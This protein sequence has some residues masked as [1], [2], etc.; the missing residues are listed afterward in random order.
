[1]ALMTLPAYAQSTDVFIEFQARCLTPM[2]EVR[3]S[4]ISGLNLLEDMA[5]RE[6]WVSAD[7]DWHLSR[8]APDAVVAFCTVHG[9]IG[10]EVDTWAEA[11]AASGEWIRLELARETLQSTYQREPVIEV[12]I[13]REGESLTV[14]ET[15]LES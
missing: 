13:D 7:A 10:A 4:D 6:T 14:I 11:A 2:L 12:E 8:S 9:A 5:T 3:D 15:N 1:M